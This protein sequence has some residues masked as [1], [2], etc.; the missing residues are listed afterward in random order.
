MLKVAVHPVYTR[1]SSYFTTHSRIINLVSFPKLCV[2]RFETLTSTDNQFIYLKDYVEKN[3][4]NPNYEA[5][6]K[7]SVEE[8]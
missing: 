2:K 1:L 3:N 4:T 8:K 5:T 6:M 7:S